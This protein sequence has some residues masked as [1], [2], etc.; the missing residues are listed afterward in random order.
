M[1]PLLILFIVMPILE[2]WVLISVGQ[3]IGALPTIGLV[4]L[5]AVVGL[6]LLRRQGI[7]TVMRAQQK[8]QAGEMPAREMAEGIFLAVGGALLLTPGFVTDAIGFACLIPGLRQLILGKLL[9]RVVVI[10]T[11][12]YGRYTG[13]GQHPGQGP[14]PDR[15]P[16]AHDVIEGDYEREDRKDRD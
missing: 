6:A 15:Q 12:S 9:S 8:M 7:S 14:Q 11:S 16:G 1:R 13:A 10:Q 4:L 3:Q 2:M 5:T